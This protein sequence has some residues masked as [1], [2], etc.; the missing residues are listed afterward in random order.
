VLPKVKLNGKTIGKD[1]SSSPV[2]VDMLQTSGVSAC[3]T[4]DTK[5]IVPISNIGI[6][7]R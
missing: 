5:N 6:N 3:V 7:S 1:P 4:G 2:I